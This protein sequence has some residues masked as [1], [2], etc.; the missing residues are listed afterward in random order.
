MK[1]LVL[2][3]S[4][5]VLVLTLLLN[6]CEGDAT[7]SPLVQ[8]SDSL[9]ATLSITPNPPVPMNQAV[10][11]LKLSDSDD[12]PF[13]GAQISLDLTMPGMT[14]PINRPEVT[15][16]GNGVYRARA[17]FTMAGKWRIEAQ[18]TRAGTSRTFTFDLNIKH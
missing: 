13:S 15:E 9:T 2:L 3:V 4:V 18:V 7:P 12:R 8:R 11:E 10:L 5:L 16:K 6:G 17:L 1:Y 14:M